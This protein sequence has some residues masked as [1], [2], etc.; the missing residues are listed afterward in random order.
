MTDVAQGEEPVKLHHLEVPVS[1]PQLGLGWPTHAILSCS[2]INS[3]T[4]QPER[5]LPPTPGSYGPTQVA[6]LT[7]LR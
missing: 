5:K 6:F 2:S 1:S 3:L 4:G 7:F